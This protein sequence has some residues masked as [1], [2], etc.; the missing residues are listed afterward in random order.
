[1]ASS[2]IYGGT[3]GLRQRPAI[4]CAFVRV[5]EKYIPDLENQIARAAIA[6]AQ[7]MVRAQA[8]EAG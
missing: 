3:V 2:F 4:R 1:M 8:V 7:F 6:H 5:F